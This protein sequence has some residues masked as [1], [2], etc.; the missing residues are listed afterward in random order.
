MSLESKLLYCGGQKLLKFL[1][2][3]FCE[4]NSFKFC[5]IFKCNAV[6]SFRDF[7]IFLLSNLMC[8]PG[9]YAGKFSFPGRTFKEG[10]ALLKIYSSSLDLTLIENS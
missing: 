9:C 7:C 6:S 8:L 3:V 5:E 4:T 1:S 2:V 10:I